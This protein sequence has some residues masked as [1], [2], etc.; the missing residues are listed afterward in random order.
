MHPPWNKSLT[1][2]ARELGKLL[3]AAHEAGKQQEAAQ[4]GPIEPEPEEWESVR[5]HILEKAVHDAQD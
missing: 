2:T 5:A 4:H 1:L 3:D